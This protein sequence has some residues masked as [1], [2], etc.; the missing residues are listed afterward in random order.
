MIVSPISAPPSPSD[1]VE[2]TLKETL[3][4]LD[5]LLGVMWVPMAAFNEPAK[6]WEGRYALTCKWP[7]IDGRWQEVQAG[8]VPE[9]EALD[10]IGWLCEDMQN[11]SSVPTSPD[12][13][14]DRVLALLGTMDNA[15]YPWKDRMRSVVKKNQ[16]LYNTQKKDAADQANR[17]AEHFYRQ[18]KGVPQST[19]ANFYKGALI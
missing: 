3:Q 4:R 2:V 14:T 7:S 15:R 1:T 19:G 18:A 16:E 9:A 12:G 10:I 5:P 13:I 17:A 6:R 8:K 11:A